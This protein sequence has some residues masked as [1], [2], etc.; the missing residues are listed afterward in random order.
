MSSDSTRLFF[1]LLGHL[2]GDDAL[3]QALDDGGLADARL[4]DQHRVVLG[5]PLQHLDGAA[6]LLV[7]ADDRVELALAG[8]LG[9][10]EAV[11]LER[12]AV[13]FGFGA[14]DL[15]AA[16][17]RVDRGFERL[18]R[19]AVLARDAAD[20]LLAVGQRQ[21]HQL[22]GDVLVAALEAFLLG[23]LQQRTS[24]R[25]TWTCSWPCT[26]GR[27][28]IA[29]GAGQQAGHVDAGALQ[30]RA[31]AVLLPQHGHQQVL[32][33]DVLVVVGQGQALGLAQGL[34]ELGGEFVESHGKSPLTPACAFG[35]FS[36]V[37]N[38]SPR[39][40]AD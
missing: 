29:L 28:C 26:W 25:P 36:R 16:A 17:H 5:A 13:A 35:G 7:A 11:L 22:A 24:S 15:L 37:G 10:V 33:F 21:Q 12:L 40:W 1:R 8:A 20:V 38:R 23:G 3:G 14:V 19:Q 6:D 4:A 30:Q 9:E 39:G 18:A 2:A 32:G 31:R 27:L 34:L